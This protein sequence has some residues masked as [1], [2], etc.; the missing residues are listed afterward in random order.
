LNAIG[1]DLNKIV[2]LSKS[3][4]VEVG[5]EEKS[6]LSKLDLKVDDVVNQLIAFVGAGRRK[7]FVRAVFPLEGPISE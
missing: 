5:E 6:F 7:T 1:I 4:P 2:K 3:G